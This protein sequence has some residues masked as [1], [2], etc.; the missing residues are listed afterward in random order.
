M[1]WLE[2]AVLAVL[3]GV[4]EFL[5][6]SSSGHLVIAEALL[7][8]ESEGTLEVNIILH[9]G[10]LLS[11]L[12]F[13]WHRVWRL[14][15]EDRR[16]IGLLVMGTIPAVVVG[17][18][19][20]KFA[21]GL[22]ESPLLAGCMLPLTGWML[23]WSRRHENGQQQ[24]QSLSYGQT[25]VLG[26]CQAFAILPGISRSGA[27]ICG[28]LALGLRRDSA[29]TFAFLMAI[30]VIAG[31]TVLNMKDLIS[32]GP[33]AGGTSLDVLAFGAALSFFVG[34]GSLS[35]L[36]RIIERGRLYRFAWWCIPLGVGVVIWQLLE[37]M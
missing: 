18:P 10:T 7:G 11:I 33:R 9:A 36:V 32:D 13:Y 24:Y 8:I 35:L 12:V 30:P 27:T 25:F 37:T 4:A 3:Q 28:G 23:L 29:A 15:G 19:L 17:L 5:P 34:L 14:I 26:L 31:A 2:I 21:P 22:L 6:I 16:V 1:S 20:K